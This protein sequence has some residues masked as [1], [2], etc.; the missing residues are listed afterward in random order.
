MGEPIIQGG[1]CPLRASRDEAVMWSGKP[2]K[3]DTPGC[4]A[5]FSV[6]RALHCSRNRGINCR[7]TV[8]LAFRSGQWPKRRCGIVRPCRYGPAV[9]DSAE[10]SSL[11]AFALI[12][13]FRKNSP[14]ISRRVVS[15]CGKGQVLRRQARRGCH[16][17]YRNN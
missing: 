8:F 5:S 11:H 3:R 17:C 6:Y 1:D 12:A 14:G 10:Q 15:G 13:G 16:T 2:T 7:E 4:G 9:S